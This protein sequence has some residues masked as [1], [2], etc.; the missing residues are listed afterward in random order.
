MTLACKTD[1]ANPTPR[2]KWTGLNCDTGNNYHT[3][4]YTPKPG[5]HDGKT[6]TCTAR[7]PSSPKYLSASA[8]FTINIS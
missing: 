8:N 7:N 6:V 3:C 5:L 1:N 2:Y 4:S